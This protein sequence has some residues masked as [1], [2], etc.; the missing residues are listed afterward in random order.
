[1]R[2]IACNARP[3][4]PDAVMRGHEE[5][6]E[7]ELTPADDVIDPVC[8][9][10]ITTAQAPFTRLHAGETYYLCSVECSLRFDADG[11]AYAAT[12]RLNLPGWGQT[13][14][15]PSVVEQFRPPSES[16]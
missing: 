6:P 9:M 11:E 14:H 1:M 8:G 2:I 16:A 7:L 3:S 13:P 12:A 10:R 15:P 5:T 4:Y